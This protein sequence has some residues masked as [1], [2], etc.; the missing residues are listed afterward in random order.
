MCPLS[1]AKKQ[2]VFLNKT[3]MFVSRPK[4]IKEMLANLWNLC[5]SLLALSAKCVHLNPLGIPTV[6]LCHLVTMPG[7][8]VFVRLI[9]D[10]RPMLCQVGFF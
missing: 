8:V 7:I 1:N 6:K 4:R 10:T 2:H 3:S 5:R 9:G